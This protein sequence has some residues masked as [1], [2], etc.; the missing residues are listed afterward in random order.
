M[1]FTSRLEMLETFVNLPMLSDQ[2]RADYADQLAAEKHHLL[3][4]PK[5]TL[6]I[7]SAT[8]TPV[9]RRGRPRG[10]KETRPRYR[11]RIHGREKTGEL[12]TVEQEIRQLIRPARVNTYAR[13]SGLSAATL[14]KRIKNG[15]LRAFQENGI[16]VVEPVEFLRYWLARTNGR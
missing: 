8:T 3:T 5:R 7:A 12:L 6:V 2:A 16:V 9:K 1:S 14:R 10:V 15:H 11:G 4:R 13:I